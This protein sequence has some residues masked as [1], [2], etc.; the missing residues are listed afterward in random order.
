M[1]ISITQVFGY[2]YQFSCLLEALL[3]KA[4]KGRRTPQLEFLKYRGRINL[5]IL[6]WLYP[7]GNIKHFKILPSRK[8]I[9]GYKQLTFIGEKL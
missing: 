4:V 3:L 5:S 9:F 1:V 7:H 2:S 6:Q 8:E